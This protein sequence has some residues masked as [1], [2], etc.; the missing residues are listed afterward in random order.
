MAIVV[1]NCSNDGK[2]VVTKDIS[3]DLQLDPGF[4]LRR[5]QQDLATLGTRIELW[6]AAKRI[7]EHQIKVSDISAPDTGGVANETLF[8][9]AH[10]VDN[11]N[12]KGINIEFV[13]RLEGEE[14]LYPEP[15]LAL[16]YDIYDRIRSISDVPVPRIFA[17]E[18]DIS[19]L[20]TRFM[21]MQRAPGR[22]VPDRPNYNYGGWLHDMPVRERELVWQEAVG[23]MA[24]LHQL[25]PSCFAGLQSKDPVANGLA[26]NLAY[27]R[28]Y[29]KW[30]NGEGVNLI[31]I[32]EEWLSK[33]LPKAN[34][35]HACIS[36]GDARM[37]NL[38]FEG[39]HCTALLDWDMVSLAGAEADLAWWTIADH[40][41]TAS[42]GVQRLAGIGSPG[43]TMRLWEAIT[44][45]KLKCMDWHLVF[46]AYRQALVSIQLSNL[47]SAAVGYVPKITE[48]S[49]GLQWLSQLLEVPLGADITLPFVGL[50]K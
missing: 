35:T 11:N 39:T 44:G 1:V 8:I 32:A 16:H 30:C 43:D 7:G 2:F 9:S 45:R 24:A 37:Q 10:Y 23:T 19:V 38:M 17:F 6:W 28:R 13:L 20:G 46:A 22:P 42:R 41:Y 15:D 47:Y 36:W 18:T 40:K 50:E 31:C 48:P 33:M 4:S 3:I 14:F 25:D 29:A 34:D 26:E 49:I 21:L 27:W 5:S 12:T